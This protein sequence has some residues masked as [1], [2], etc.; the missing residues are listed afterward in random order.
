M[1]RV[2]AWVAGDDANCGEPDLERDVS[3][4]DEVERERV[5]RGEGEGGQ[6]KRQA[7]P[8][9]AG[10]RQS[11]R[12]RQRRSSHTQAFSSNR[13]AEATS[14]RGAVVGSSMMLNKLPV[15]LL[16]NVLSCKLLPLCLH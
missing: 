11:Y 10:A 8:Q 2:S 1:A 4:R 12:F 6:H 3:C 14:E 5:E 9:K 15:E 16:E 13:S 7:V